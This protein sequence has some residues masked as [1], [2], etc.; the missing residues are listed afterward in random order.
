MHKKD[1]HKLAEEAKLDG[2]HYMVIG[3]VILI[4]VLDG[5]D[6]AISVAIAA[7]GVIG[8]IEVVLINHRVSASTHDIEAVTERETDARAIAVDGLARA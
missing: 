5:Y 4:L 2:F 1:I 3:W 7:V 6:I 8:A